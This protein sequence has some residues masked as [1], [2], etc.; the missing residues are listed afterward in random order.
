MKCIAPNLMGVTILQIRDRRRRWRQFY[1]NA[2]GTKL[3]IRHKVVT[4]FL[5]AEDNIISV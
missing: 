1:S 3:M 4:D 2:A 5:H